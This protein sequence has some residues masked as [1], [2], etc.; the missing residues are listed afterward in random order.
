MHKHTKTMRAVRANVYTHDLGTF[1]RNTRGANAQAP[2]SLVF[3]MPARLKSHAVVFVSLMLLRRSAHTAYSFAPVSCTHGRSKRHVEQQAVRHAC[4]GLFRCSSQRIRP[5]FATLLL[6][7]FVF[8]SPSVA[9]STTR[10]SMI[11]MNDARPSV[12]EPS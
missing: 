3:V 4:W 9:A 6:C 8:S 2:C 1:K 5:K 10:R 7:G 11:L 12:F